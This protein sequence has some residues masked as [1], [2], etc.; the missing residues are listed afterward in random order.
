MP[1]AEA[2]LSN[3]LTFFVEDCLAGRAHAFQRSK[4]GS[5]R[6]RRYSSH[7]LLES[8]LWLHTGLRIGY[9][10]VEGSRRVAYEFLSDFL[11]AYSALIEKPNIREDKFTEPV[12]AVL[13]SELSGRAP[14]FGGAVSALSTSAEM[15]LGFQSLL[16]LM[17]SFEQEES[18]SRLAELLVFGTE[19]D[20]GKLM[21]DRSGYVETDWSFD[22]FFAMI[23]FME[24][25]RETVSC[26]SGNDLA[27][28]RQFL[29][30]IQE[31]RFSFR[32][33][34]VHERFLAL[35]KLVGAT[36][37]PAGQINDRK[38]LLE[39]H[40]LATDWGAIPFSDSAGGRS[41]LER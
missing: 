13:D 11:G 10:P 2:Q 8:Y 28:L 20:W 5:V 12:R 4:F 17:T 23:R 36:L 24:A 18:S 26:L 35:G 22:G 3:N 29:R 21:Q 27:T 16:L 14:L 32:E 15:S 40:E 30:E 9:F 31:W 41:F 7:S 34:I 1:Y 39:I 25:Y 37:G 33:K 19:I 6:S 38:L